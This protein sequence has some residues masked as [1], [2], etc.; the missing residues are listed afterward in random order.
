MIRSVIFDLDGLLVDSEQNSLQVLNEF[1]TAYGHPLTRR[2]F[3]ET[4]SGRSA[5][6]IIS[7]MLE[8]YDIP[9]TFAKARNMIASLEEKY[10]DAGVSLKTGATELLAFLKENGYLIA[11]ATSSYRERAEHMLAHTH[12]MPY[13]TACVYA[14]E[15][16]HG[17]PAPDLFLTA[18]KKLKT[19]PSQC[20]VLE[21]SE[22]GIAAAH[23]AHIPVINIP[24]MHAP[25]ST[26][27][28]MTVAQY[29]S[30]Y[31]VITYLEQEH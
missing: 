17:K 2:E 7:H 19:A 11:L 23:A 27:I 29:P 25:S 9:L 24:D 16:S 21:D 26:Y 6:T 5:K 10:L 12:V 1:L 20:L 22:A 13:F 4:Y 31:D 30:L 3:A 28:A 15:V 8:T 18:A 14:D